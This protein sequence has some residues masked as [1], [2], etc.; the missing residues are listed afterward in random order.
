MFGMVGL[1]EAVNHLM[2]LSGTTDK[3]GHSKKADDLVKKS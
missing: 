2:E 3:F 1:A